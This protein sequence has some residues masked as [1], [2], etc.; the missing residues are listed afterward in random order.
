M[1]KVLKIGTRGSHLALQQTREVVELLRSVDSDIDYEVIVIQSSG[2]YGIRQK[3]GAF[4]SELEMALVKGQVR[5]AVHSQK[6][7]P[8]CN[9]PH[10]VTAA[11]LPRAITNDVLISRCDKA[12]QK[13]TLR[14][15]T[16]SARR[17][18][19]LSKLH[20]K[21]IFL[22]IQGN[23]DS[24]IKRLKEDESLD[25][26]V[27]AYAAL[28]RGGFF[29]QDLH[30]EL[31]PLESLLP[32]PGQAAIAVQC[33]A[34]DTF[35][36]NLCQK[37]NHPSTALCVMLEREFLRL[38]GGGCNEPFGC[39]ATIQQGKIHIQVQWLT[40]SNT[41][42]KGSWCFADEAQALASIAEIASR[43]RNS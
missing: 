5:A 41:F 6:D 35:M 21:W 43:W 42:L 8:I 33:L 30:S 27:I 38:L 40:Q 26:I 36:R 39:L 34:E 12:S 28:Q 17:K 1:N 14:V 25:A 24:R 13:D 16:S 37:I 11:V 4:T 31:I 7:L 3:R 2:D 19:F 32:A 18:A 9:H 23:I 22:E 10:T 20:P 29:L 15:G